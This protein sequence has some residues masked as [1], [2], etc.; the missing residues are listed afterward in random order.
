MLGRI[1]STEDVLDFFVPPD[2]EVLTEEK[3]DIDQCLD[4]EKKNVEDITKRALLVNA[5]YEEDLLRIAA[6]KAK[7]GELQARLKFRE[8]ARFLDSF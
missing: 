4:L 5:E 2:D 3:R 8:G 7:K 1:L 6:L